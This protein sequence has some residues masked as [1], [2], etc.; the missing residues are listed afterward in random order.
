MKKAIMLLGTLLVALSL[1]GCNTI[2]GMG[3][4]VSAGGK[5]MSKSAEHVQSSFDDFE[6]DPSID[7]D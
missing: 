6:R 2:K 5:A 1:S 7:Y 4:D 3:E